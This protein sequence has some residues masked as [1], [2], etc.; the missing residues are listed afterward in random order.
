MVTAL[1]QSNVF[2]N[3]KKI[4]KIDRPNTG[5]DALILAMH[6]PIPGG[7]V[8]RASKFLIEILFL[9][10]RNCIVKS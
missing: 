1:R 5:L 4:K 2:Y 10:S 7:G 9:F 3:N 6:A 8:L